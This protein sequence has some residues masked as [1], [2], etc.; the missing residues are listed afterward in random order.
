MRPALVLLAL[1]AIIGCR[2]RR[3]AEVQ[4]TGAELELT[5]EADAGASRPTTEWTST[6]P[7]VVPPADLFDMGMHHPPGVE[8]QRR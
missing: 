3:P 8:E 2:S 5:N 7:R 1:A 6:G 4:L